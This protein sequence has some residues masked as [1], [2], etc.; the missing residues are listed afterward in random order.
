VLMSI[1]NNLVVL[2][3]AP[4]LLGFVVWITIRVS[5]RFRA[6]VSHFAASFY[7]ASI[8]LWIALNEKWISY[9]SLKGALALHPV[10]S[11]LVEGLSFT[12]FIIVLGSLAIIAPV[13]I[14][15]V[16]VRG[17][18]GTKKGTQQESIKGIELRSNAICFSCTSI[19]LW[20]FTAV[21]LLYG[22]YRYDHYAIM[23]FQPGLTVP[24]IV[25]VFALLGILVYAAANIREN[26]EYSEDTLIFRK[27]LI[28]LG[29]RVLIGP[30]I[31]LVAY[32]VLFKPALDQ[33]KIDALPAAAF[34][35]FFTGLY[36]KQVMNRLEQVGISMLTQES[37]KKLQERDVPSSEISDIL[38]LSDSLSGELRDNRLTTID[39]LCCLSYDDL[40]TMA[41]RSS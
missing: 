36:V 41:S 6:A 17:A 25:P 5:H 35:A 24:L 26:S 23:I 21:G 9:E 13:F 19:A 7:L 16:L 18:G 29:E 30:Y 20:S 12:A 22:Y 27:K 33:L 1:P 2:L 34:L 8:L 14:G 37:Q 11:T 15:F 39:D 38:G 32:L 4:A 3:L 40:K 10:A 31:A 28:A